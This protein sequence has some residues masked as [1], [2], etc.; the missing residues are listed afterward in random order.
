VGD[1]F[2]E[3]RLED[4]ATLA[5]VLETYFPKDVPREEAKIMSIGCGNSELSEDMHAAGYRHIWNIDI[6][7]VVIEQM[8]KRAEGRPEL[9]CR[10]ISNVD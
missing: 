7:P 3:D 1:S 8:A 2:W 5:P 4:Y 6:S 10:G 9:K